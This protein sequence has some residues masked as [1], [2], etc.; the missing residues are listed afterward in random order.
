VIIVRVSS[1]TLSGE[2]SDRARERFATQR[3]HAHIHLVPQMDVFD[4]LDG[5]GEI[6]SQVVVVGNPQQR[7]G[8]G[9]GRRAGLDERAG[10]GIAPRD[11][12]IKRG[13]DLCIVQQ[14]LI[15]LHVR[16]GGIDGR[17]GRVILGFGGIEVL[18]GDEI[19]LL[20]VD[21]DEAGVDEMSVV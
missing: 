15:L 13:G 10:V 9:S 18:L 8:L 1:E 16:F 3:F 2:T 14:R 5:H 12:A 6:E 11:H 7:L 17:R 19:G 4:V 20:L 21:P